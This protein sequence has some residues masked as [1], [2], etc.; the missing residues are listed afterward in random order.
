V[1]PPVQ[2]ARRP[3]ESPD[4]Q[5]AGF[6]RE[7]LAAGI[8]RGEWSLL[9]IEG[10]DAVLAWRWERHAIAVNWSDTPAEA[11]VPGLGLYVRLGPYGFNVVPLD[12]ANASARP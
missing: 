10:S 3:P 11:S 2:V 4:T 1:R 5:L 6:W 8:R 9:E 7:L 12:S